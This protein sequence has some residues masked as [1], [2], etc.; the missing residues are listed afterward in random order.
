MRRGRKRAGTVWSVLTATYNRWMDN[1][2]FRLSAVIAYYAVFSLPGL[3]VIIFYLVGQFY[4]PE[5]IRG[6]VYGE[7]RELIGSEGARQVQQIIKNANQGETS[8]VATVVG[9]GSLIFAATGLFFHLKISLNDIWELKAVPE[10]AWLH[11]IL[12]R[13]FS[14]TII[15][16]IGSLLLVS[17]IASTVVS[18]LSAYIPDFFSGYSTYLVDLVNFLIS[19]FIITLLFAT[20]YKVLPDAKIAWRDVWIGSL[21]TALLFVGGKVL[22]SQYLTIADP[23]SAYGAASAIILILLWASYGSLVFFLGA[24]FTAVYTQRFGT[25]ITP[26]KYAVKTTDYYRRKLG[27]SAEYVKVKSEKVKKALEEDYEVK[28]INK[29]GEENKDE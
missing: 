3:F 29:E 26:K 13:L 27:D 18:A 12:D 20:I 23:A 16:V 15:L 8:L 17:I 24:A 10:K 4:G 7:L 5:A 6:E 21:V 2:P 19:L 14:F 25:K 9:I 28:K 1:D 11:V 22:I